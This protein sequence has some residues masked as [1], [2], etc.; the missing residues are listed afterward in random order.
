MVLK[1]LKWIALSIFRTTNPRT[2]EDTVYL[3]R[4]HF[5]LDIE[6]TNWHLPFLFMFP[7]QIVPARKHSE[8]R[9]VFNPCSNMTSDVLC[10]S[11]CLGFISLDNVVSQLYIIYF[12]DSAWYKTSLAAE[13]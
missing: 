7:E 5:L 8:L 4:H 6:F 11:F 2:T 3:Q 10:T 9:V 1:L 12:V 13:R